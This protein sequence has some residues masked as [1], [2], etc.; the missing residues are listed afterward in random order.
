MS[1]EIAKIFFQR[2]ENYNTTLN[3]PEHLSYPKIVSTDNNNNGTIIV[4]KSAS[5]ILR[6]SEVNSKSLFSELNHL[7]F[8]SSISKPITLKH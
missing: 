8:S 4:I 5:L 1:T 6:E 2:S 3:L 7:I